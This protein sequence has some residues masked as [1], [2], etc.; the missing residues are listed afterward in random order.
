MEQ[1]LDKRYGA[2]AK[3]Y[4]GI[5]L[6]GEELYVPAFFGD[7]KGKMVP[8]YDRP[9]RRA[10]SGVVAID[11]L[12]R[13][14]ARVLGL[15]ESLECLTAAA[16]GAKLFVTSRDRGVFVIDIDAWRKN[17]NYQPPWVKE[18]K[19]NLNTSLLQIVLVHARTRSG[20]E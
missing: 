3:V 19:G 9:N 12:R 16:C 10:R 14:V 11:R 4:D 18:E 1:S 7:D 6:W 17:P 15:S 20:Y 2:G 13:E 8:L 5:A